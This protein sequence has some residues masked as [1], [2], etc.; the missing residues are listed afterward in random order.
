LQIGT[1]PKQ[2]SISLIDLSFPLVELHRHLD[3]NIRL[4]TILAI[5]R[6]HHLPLP[7][8]DVDGLRPFVQVTDPQPGVMAFI[9]KFHWPMAILVDGEACRRIAYENIQDAQRDG[10][11]YIELRFSPGFM[12]ESHRL[13][14]FEVVEAVLD[15]TRCGARD[16][17]VKV[18]LV[19]ILS[20]TYGAEAA[21][22]ELEA[23]LSQREGITALDLAGDEAH[24]PAGWFQ[25]HFRRA[26]EAGWHITVHAGESAGP[27]SIW[28]ALQ[29][30]GA[31]RIGHALRAV[32][33]P[34]LMDYLADHRIG[35]ESCLTS[36]VQT[37]CVPDYPHHPLRRFLEAGIPAT[38][39]T[40]DPGISGIDLR[41]EYQ[42]AAPQ[43]G[44]TP[45][46]IQKAQANALQVAFL[47][48][49]EKESLR[50]ARKSAG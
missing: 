16:F 37:S 15:G 1:P 42:V 27:E 3:G 5:G 22:R 31:E 17:G 8:W 6:Q 25:E 36:N 47:E 33:D 46:Q 13:D 44:L 24:Y 41:Y 45:Q 50:A 48:E 28:Q 40:D 7:A 14:P 49:A 29:L 35:I 20:R 12:A 19:G 2:L 10:I 4:E 21:H 43:A 39:N 18:N 32:E 34:A 11:D 38:I 9:S 30:L 26:R 23:L